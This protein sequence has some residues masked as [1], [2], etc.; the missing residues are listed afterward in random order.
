M[1]IEKIIESGLKYAQEDYLEIALGIFNDVKPKEDQ[2]KCALYRSFSEENYLVHAEASYERNKGRCDLVAIS[3][4]QDYVAIE[5]KTAWAGTG[6]VNKPKRQAS[7]WMKDID[8]LNSMKKNGFANHGYFILC[9]AYE[10]STKYHEQLYTEIKEL[11]GEELPIVKIED[12]NGL[13]TIQFFIV[14]VFG[15]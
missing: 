14:K 7:S 13:N 2:V 9:Y 10:Q 15:E 11:K 4:K 6:W 1:S 12:W 3:N 5:I 8:K